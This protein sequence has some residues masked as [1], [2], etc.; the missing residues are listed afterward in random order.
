MK[1]VRRAAVVGLW[2]WVAGAGGAALGRVEAA[3]GA[4]IRVLSLSPA[5]LTLTIGEG[6][7][8]PIT[9]I[10]KASNAATSGNPIRSTVAAATTSGGAWLSA[11]PQKITVPRRRTR[12]VQVTILPTGLT[13][14]GSPYQGT[15]TFDGNQ[16]NGTQVVDVTIV[17]VT[18]PVVELEPA[19]L[20]FD[21][22]VGGP[23]TPDS[24]AVTLTNGGGGSL[25]WTA[26]AGTTSGGAWLKVEPGTGPALGPNESTLLQVTVDP[27]VLAGLAAGTYA[28]SIQVAG[29][30]GVA[31][32]TIPVT[33]HVNSA[34]KITLSPRSLSFIDPFGGPAVDSPQ[35]VRLTNTGTAPL[36]WTSGVAP[37]SS[38]LSVLPSSG[39][40]P[41]GQSIDLQ[42][43][44][45]LDGLAAGS[46]DGTITIS[47]P[48]AVND[49]VAAETV[50]EVALDVVQDPSLTLLLPD[51]ALDYSR[52]EGS[53]LSP[54]KRLEILNSGFGL[55]PFEA[56]ATTLAGGPWLRL[57]GGAAV[58]GSLVTAQSRTIDVTVDVTGL[59][60]GTYVGQITVDSS[61]P[62]ADNVPQDV[63]VTLVVYT[64]PTL[65]V[66]VTTLTFDVPLGGPNPSPQ[67]ARVSNNGTGTLAWSVAA[68]ASGTWVSF[69]PG[70]G[71]LL[72]GGFRDVD[73]S[74]D[75]SGLAAGSYST[76]LTFT[77]TDGVGGPA[78]LGSPRTV[79]VRLNVNDVPK[80]S[81]SPASL[82]FD[83]PEGGPDPA[84]Q[85]LVLTNTGAGTL[86]WTA[87]EAASWLQVS[88]SSGSL[89][90]GQS[91][92]LTVAVDTTGLAAQVYAVA[93]E[94]G[95]NASNAPRLVPVT[96]NVHTD[97]YL[98]LAPST[99]T[100]DVPLGGASP[101]AQTAALGNAGAT[102][103]TGLTAVASESW[104]TLSS[105]AVTSLAAGA[106]TPLDVTVDVTGLA[107][108]TYVGT[109]TVSGAAGTQNSPRQI[110]VV[111]QVNLS[112]AIGLSPTSFAFV[113]PAGGPDPAVQGLT[114][115]NTGVNPLEWSATFA[116]SF[117]AWLE[118]SSTSGT[119]ASNASED[120]TIS[121]LPAGLAPGTY[122]VTMW[123]ADPD[124][125]NSPRPVFI[126]LEVQAP[127]PPT[128]VAGAFFSNKRH[129]AGFCGAL[130]LEFFLPLGMLWLLR[131]VGRRVRGVAAF[132]I[133]ALPA[134]A[135]FADE[136]PPLPRCLG[137]VQD[138]Q[139]PARL[140]PTA[141]PAVM[142]SPPLLCLNRLGA[143]AA[144]GA[145]FFSREFEADPEAVV[146][147]LL[148]SPSPC[149]SRVLSSERDVLGFFVQAAATQVDRDI[150][151]LRDPDGRCF[152]A[153]GGFDV[154][155]AGSDAGF[156]RVQAGALY[157]RFGGVS[158]L[159]DGVAALVGLQ[160]GL[161]LCQ[162]L[163][164]TASPQ[165]ALG[166]GD[167]VYFLQ[168]GLA[169][170]F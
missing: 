92:T 56:T 149:L 100:F 3:Q 116:P 145:A 32:G 97:P 111:L 36:V 6:G 155:V 61:D 107:A 58:S 162:G 13:A 124:A 66:S 110:N 10:I 120:V 128:V 22:P 41:S 39:T 12:D 84:S 122:T 103:L 21:S 109:V 121:V 19:T 89:L 137:Q 114:V 154:E 102:T 59:A 74:V 165:V 62:G 91:A 164:L 54:A 69:S 29:G 43:S 132:L 141:P 46:Y 104:I 163:A 40:L 112:P 27:G 20:Q 83:A 30:S 126:S 18:T 131:R 168:A 2:A 4:P 51:G 8:A 49:G 95:G 45:A 113:R 78:A 76:S 93:I 44:V 11:S 14:A 73:V 25:A 82:V 34:A 135:A 37:A 70:S 160:A 156:V 52:P 88:P 136:D 16:T 77:A 94:V 47:D 161:N 170:R 60:A 87:S 42:V 169:V 33:L 35:I 17:V 85:S 55:L 119:L 31:P 151:G 90:A 139:D 63:F 80:I 118:V 148:R 79:I 159:E 123:I 67:T 117:P 86:D 48:A 99:M 53:G 23:A 81:L 138:E 38:W 26:T 24:A 96:L 50:V 130:G 167:Q 127:D 15:I 108:G 143:Q 140:D 142:K 157:G 134:S 144:V 7:V 150:T 65:G 125:T 115:S 147:L 101:A 153:G 9:R 1:A 105:L 5:S 158:D 146:S 64:P 106:S 57:D 133:A 28:G 98:T 129:R 72:S 71:S 68:G 152:F 166:A 75:V